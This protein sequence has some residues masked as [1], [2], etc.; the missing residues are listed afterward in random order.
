MI[1]NLVDFQMN[2][3]DATMAPRFHHQ[4]LPDKLYMEDGFSPDTKRLLL[5]KGHHLV[6]SQSMGSLQSILYEA[7]RF[8][9]VSDSRRPDAAAVAV[10]MKP[11]PA[12]P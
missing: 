2:V 6:K 11:A 12:A 8:Y 1:V 4:W 10:P 5:G 7:G 3:A 9:G